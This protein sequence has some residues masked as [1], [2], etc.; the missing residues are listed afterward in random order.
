MI[1]VINQYYGIYKVAVFCAMYQGG[2]PKQMAAS[3][4][5]LKQARQQGNQERADDDDG[6]VPPF[7]HAAFVRHCVC[8]AMLYF[9][10][11]R[12]VPR[13]PVVC[14]ARKSKCL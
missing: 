10:S 14:N 8:D 11:V 2:S 13:F 12:I 3:P 9:R 4:P 1:Q 6:K 5:S 7:P